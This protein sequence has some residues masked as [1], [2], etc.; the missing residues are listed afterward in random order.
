MKLKGID[1]GQHKRWSIWRNEDD[2]KSSCPL[3]LGRHICYNGWDKRLR[4][5]KGELMPNT[6]PQFRLLAATRL[7]EA[8]VASN[9]RSAIRR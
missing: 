4:S 9:R 3:C 8:G 2:V 7:H 6:C 1:R 5:C